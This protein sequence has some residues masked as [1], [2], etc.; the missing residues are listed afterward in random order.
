MSVPRPGVSCIEIGPN[1][2]QSRMPSQFSAGCGARQRFF[3]TG[4]AAKGIPLNTL[5]RV[6][7]PGRPRTRPFSVFTTF[8]IHFLL[9]FTRGQAARGAPPSKNVCILYRFSA[10]NSTRIQC[11]IPYCLAFRTALTG[12][13][14]ALPTS[15]DRSLP[16]RRGSPA[17]EH[18]KAPRALCPGRFV[19]SHYVRFAV[20]RRLSPQYAFSR[21]G[22]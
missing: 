11:V 6:L 22:S 1:S 10:E 16:D 13:K 2:K 3:P 7:L 15:P 18:G 14:E 19:M 17:A 8:N 20:V 21:C 5:M 9:I 12:Q 4:G